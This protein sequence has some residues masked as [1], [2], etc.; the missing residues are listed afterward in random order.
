M[1]VTIAVIARSAVLAWCLALTSAAA[2]QVVGDEPRP[3]PVPARLEIGA[4]GGLMVA[5]P[6]LSALASVPLGPGVSFEIAAGWMPRVIYEVEH[7]LAQV[8]FRLPFRS[9]LRSRR[10]LLLGVTR[11]ST[12]K[13]GRF[14]PGFWDSDANK[15][16][17]HGG[18]SLQWPIRPHM[19]FRFDA[20]GLFTLDSTLPLAARASALV[21]WHPGGG[22]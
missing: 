3:V 8:Q 16:F 14:D 15:V 4:G 18:V 13:R 10:S 22:S 7:A 1:V 12:R 20:Q 6:E 11:V 17:P 5:Y 2:A 21:V 19:D 9:H